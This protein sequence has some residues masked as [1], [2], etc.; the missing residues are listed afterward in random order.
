M[1]KKKERGKENGKLTLE[2]RK[3]RRKK[4]NNKLSNFVLTVSD[5][6]IG[7]PANINPENSETLGLQL[8]S[9]L[10]DQLDGKLEL[11]RTQGA[12]FIIKF[13]A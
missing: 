1:K 3:D 2:R 12:E 10:V 5:N 4:D 8:I 9:I 11:N 6:G 7:I 13:R